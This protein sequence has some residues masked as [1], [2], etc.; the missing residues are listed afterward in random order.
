MNFWKKSLMARLVISFLLLSMTIVGLGGYVTFIQAKAVL[1]ESAFDRLKAVA[2]LKEDELNR[3]IND[4]T[5]D[6]QFIAQ[7]P[8]VQIQG[9][10]L[11][12]QETT[13]VDRQVAYNLLSDYFKKAIADKQGLQE[14]FILDLEGQVIVSSNDK[15]VGK[16]RTSEAYFLRGKQLLFPTSILVQNVYISPETDRPM[17]T[18]V[19]PLFDRAGVRIGLMGVHLYLERL[20]R[21][22]MDRTGL[23]ETGETYL[24]DKASRFVSEARFRSQGFEFPQGI[25]SPGI[26]AALQGHDGTGL[27]ANYQGVEVIGVYRWLDEREMALLAEMSQ[28]EAFAPAR[29]LAQST[30]LIG[31]CAAGVLTIGVYLLAR[32]IARPILAIT[33]TA[34][35]VTAGDLT[36]T[37]PVSTQDEVGALAQ[38]FNRMTEQLRTLYERV[39][40]RLHT[41]VSNVPIILYALDE[42]GRFTLVEGKGLES[43]RLEPEH[44]LGRPAGE[45]LPQ[46]M[47]SL[48]HTLAAGAPFQGTVEV[49]G[50]AFESWSAPLRNGQG[51]A[52]G[53]IGVLTDITE[54]KRAEEQL[55]RAKE[56]AETANR[57]KSQFL[58]NMS[59]ELRTPLNAI[60]GYS[61]MLQEDAADMGEE[62]FVSDLQQINTAGRHLL[63]LI[64]DVLDLSK[65]EA[66]K[67]DLY[68]E[69][70]NVLG[71]ID[72]VANTI[73]PIIAKNGNEFTVSC[74]AEVGEMQADITKVRQ[75]IFNLLSNAAKFTERGEVRLSVKR[76]NGLEAGPMIQFQVAD[77]GIGMTPEQVANLFQPFTQADASTTRRYGGTGLGLAIS[78][79]FC[80]MMGGDIIVSSSLGQGSVFTITLPAEVREVEPPPLPDQPVPQPAPNNLVLVIDDDPTA[81]EMLSHFLTREGFRVEI[82]T[83]GQAGLHLARELRPSVITLDVMMPG[84]D[85]WAVLTKLKADPDLADIPV[86]MVTIVDDKNLGYTLKASDY[87]LKPIERQRLLAV[88]DK[89]HHSHAG[90]ETILLVEDDAVTRRMVRQMLEKEGWQVVE[91]ANG[92]AALSYLSQQIPCLILLDLMMP[93]MDGFQFINE[94]RQA[95]REEWQRIPIVV[96]TAMDLTQ[97]E[98][99]RLNGYVQQILQKGGYSQEELLREVRD[100]VTASL[101]ASHAT[102]GEH[103]S[104]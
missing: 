33:E 63:A 97:E 8:L 82:A 59:H 84:M 29:E 26:S 45:I 56:A 64:N 23:G 102:T 41:I 27:Y 62:D 39:S 92:W 90:V 9:G 83:G 53:L 98:R 4:Q 11:L 43:L 95:G 94:L 99:L 2:V 10:A 85:G 100:L 75:T 71:M 51:E 24:I 54:R 28:E 40:E 101:H 80:R 7:L 55:Q 77:T 22:I 20:N 44:M 70:F 79:H 76:I 34:T 38:T 96:V 60:I 103:H 89:Y 49:A 61:E 18:I 87:I 25:Y 52:E 36:L 68:L 31:L 3:W 42:E 6:V 65:I 17:M 78:R 12:G 58:A 21:I 81:A 50:L 14:I 37:A 88:L 16:N 66:G 67:M 74:P 57:A 46:L 69:T 19:L 91:A 104:C 93:E 1:Q 72:D 30:L 13:A 86:V 32:Q 47:D 73:R 5:R 15:Y 48:H 35:R